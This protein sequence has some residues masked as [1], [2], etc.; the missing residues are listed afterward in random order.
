MWNAALISARAA[1]GDNWEQVGKVVE[2]F[3]LVAV[4]V[5][6]AVVAWF[7]FQRLI[8]ARFAPGPI[9]TPEAVRRASAPGRN[10]APGP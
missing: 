3:Q 2:R 9:Q 6:V 1:L 8:K 10:H 7:L 5:I 4:V